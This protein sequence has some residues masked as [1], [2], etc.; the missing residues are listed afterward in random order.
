MSFVIDKNALY[1]VRVYFIIIGSV[2]NKLALAIYGRCRQPKY[3]IVGSTN[4]DIFEAILCNCV[5][6]MRIVITNRKI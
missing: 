3:S 6:G 4:P 2:W 1:F 5:D